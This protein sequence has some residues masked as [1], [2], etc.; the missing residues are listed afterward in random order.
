[1]SVALRCATTRFARKAWHTYESYLRHS[2][3]EVSRPSH[4]RRFHGELALG[5]VYFN[6]DNF[7]A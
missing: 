2:Q 7:I 6:F 1:M 4:L 5:E 3:G